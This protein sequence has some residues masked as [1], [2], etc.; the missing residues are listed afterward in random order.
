MTINRKHIGNSLDDFLKSEG[1]FEE[2]RRE[3]A[4]QLLA[5]QLLDQMKRKKMSK[6]AMAKRMG[7]SRS[8]LDKILDPKNS[9]VTLDTLQRAAIAL[10]RRLK[11]E[12]V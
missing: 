9:D 2:V 4:K 11:V 5:F 8:H 12:L 10:G 7:T 1:I 6:V 3:S